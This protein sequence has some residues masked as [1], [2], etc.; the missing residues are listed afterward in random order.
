MKKQILSLLLAGVMTLSLFGC[1][2]TPGLA[3]D[4]TPAP[5]A[6]TTEE[7]VTLYIGTTKAPE[8][9]STMYERDAFGRMNYNSFCAAPF[10]ERDENGVVQPNIMTD[11]TFS[12][13]LTSM[14]ATFATDQGITWHDGEPLTMDDI[15]FTFNYLMDVKKSSYIHMLESVE[16]INDTQMKLNF[17]GPSA[18]NFINYACMAV[19]VYP[20]HIWKDVDEPNEYHEADAAVGCGPYRFVSWDE[21][22]QTMYFDAVKDYFKGELAIQHVV[23]RTYDSQDALVMALRNGEIDAIYDYSNSLNSTMAPSITGIEGVNPGMSDNPGQYQLVFGFNKQPTGDLAFR[24]AVRDALDYE[25]LAATIGGENAEIGGVGLVAPPNKGY[26][27]KLPRLS[28]DVEAALTALDEAGYI[29]TDGDGWRELPDGSQMDVLITAPYST[30]KKALFDRLSEIIASNL[31]NVGVKCSIDDQHQS[32]TD[33]Y[34]A[35]IYSGEY[36]I[37]LGSTS[38]GVAAYETA[39][40]YYVNK[41]Y[42]NAWGTYSEPEFVQTYLDMMNSPNYEIYNERVKALQKMAAEN[43]IGMPLAWDKCYF[44]YRTDRFEGWINYPGWGVINN[45]TWYN[46]HPIAGM[47][48]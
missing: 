24:K 13:D 29:D 15:E 20:E 28:Q 32:D 35:F 46:V 41:G 21:D 37:T 3:G 44:P 7:P 2:G 39:F 47:D 4:E 22:A 42:G 36:E 43:V 23:V 6:Q 17:D 16:R 14:V 1:S 40:Y 18:F 26:N 31:A 19:F 8:V 12:D 27:S 25:L 48:D 45:K 34:R 11:W 30:T 10:L 38:P 5:T 9:M 33:T